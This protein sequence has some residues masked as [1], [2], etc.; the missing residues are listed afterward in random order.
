[1]WAYL[2]TRSLKRELRSNGVIRVVPYPIVSSRTQT[3]TEG[4]LHEDTGRRQSPTRCQHATLW[5][6]LISLIPL[7]FKTFYSFLCVFIFPTKTVRFWK[8]IFILCSTQ[9]LTQ[10]NN[11]LLSTKWSPQTFLRSV[12]QERDVIRFLYLEI[13]L[14]LLILIHPHGTPL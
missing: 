14:H 13:V 11:L 5:W 2:E 9:G 7:T 4:R 10:Y 3:Y 1:M 8:S 6:C 12:S